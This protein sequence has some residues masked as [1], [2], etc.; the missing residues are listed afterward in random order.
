MY[1]A[2]HALYNRVF[3]NDTPVRSVDDFSKMNAN[4]LVCFIQPLWNTYDMGRGEGKMTE[5]QIKELANA[6]QS[7]KDRGFDISY[8]TQG[9]GAPPS[10]GGC[11]LM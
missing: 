9:A 1:S 3:G 2:L 11:C 6:M 10:M 5:H 7:Y 4:D 8:F